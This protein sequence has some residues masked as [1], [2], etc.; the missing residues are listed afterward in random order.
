MK[1]RG[2][3]TAV[4][5]KGNEI[6]ALCVFR[7]DFLEKIFFDSNKESVERQLR[8]SSVYDEVKD[9]SSDEEKEEYC[10]YLVEK[11][12]RKLNKLLEHKV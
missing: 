6:Y 8:N 12:E 1:K 11:I 5:A 4:V 7:G 10:K 9:I 2:S 3:R